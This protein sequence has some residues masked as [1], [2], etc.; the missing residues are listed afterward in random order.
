MMSIPTKM[1]AVIIENYGGTEV[2]QYK[3]V[4]VPSIGDDELLVRVHSAGVSPFD[5]HVR[6]G[7]YKKDYYALPI[8]LGW[9]LSGIV[10]AMGENVSQF[11]VGDAVFSYPN[12]YRAGGSH[13][14][15]NVIKASEAAHKPASINHHQAAAASMNTL[16][17]WQA[18]G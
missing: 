11:K 17:A 3:E 7:W 6:E 2:L 9:E 14:E 4:A 5:I 16:T 1:Q 15:Y 13:A 10:V 18:G 12:A 8:I